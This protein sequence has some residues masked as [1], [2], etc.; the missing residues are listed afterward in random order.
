ML[1]HFQTRI[2]DWI[3]AVTSSDKPTGLISDDQPTGPTSSDKPPGRNGLFDMVQRASNTAHEG[4]AFCNLG[5]AA[6]AL[7]TLVLVRSANHV[8]EVILT[9]TRTRHLRP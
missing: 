8:A 3:S 6:L 4:I 5:S 2:A 7:Q 9:L 1:E